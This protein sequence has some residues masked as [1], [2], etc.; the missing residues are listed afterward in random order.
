MSHHAI[1]GRVKRT[2]KHLS[3]TKV[4]LTITL[5]PSKLEAAEQVALTKLAKK[6]KAPGFRKGNVPISVAKKYVDQ[7]TLL[8]QTLDD[9]LSKAVAEAF[10]A[11]GL[12]ALEQPAV[13]VKKFVPG[14]QLEFTAEA[15]I[16]PAVK[17]GNYKKLKSK[18]SVENV[19]VKDV[20][21][22][23]T[24]LKSGMADKKEA[25]RAAKLGDEVI[26][27]FVGK[28]DGTA[29]EGGTASEYALTLGSDSFIPGFEAGLVGLKAG[30]KKDL[31]LQF[32]KDY[33]V[34]DLA[35][36][37]VVF[38]TTIKKVNEVVE[39]KLDDEF[40]KKAGPFKTTKELKDDIKRELAAQK[41][42]EATEKLKDELVSE[43]V[44]ASDVPAPD[45]LIA[46]QERS[47]EQ[48]TMQNLAY[49]GLTLE[50]Y[51]QQQGFADKN[52]W[53]QQEVRPMAEKR[54][55]AGLLLA[56]L[57]KVEKIEATS[58]ELAEHINRYR[59]QYQNNPEALKQ[60]EQPEVQRDIANRL[61]TEKTVDR[62]V[63]LNTK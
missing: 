24:R 34:A 49:R 59:Q 41:E 40:A 51:L 62:L 55:R 7:Q 32:P 38:E 43:L 61:I 12:R 37:D 14:K 58:E 6:V 31:Q 28:K 25:K 19:T 39:P 35:G 13:E 56:E 63:E 4:E 11:E 26:I 1:V 2:V 17:L 60:F 30:D 8:Q 54:V 21:D 44:T 16:L 53:L 47:I 46:D 20:D 10:M 23:I 22:V 48:D 18:K 15:A 27:D 3:D 33:H 57:S 36:A 42:R 5:E 29:F 50:Q 9:A 45:V 52:A